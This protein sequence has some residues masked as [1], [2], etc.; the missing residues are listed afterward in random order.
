[1]AA[2]TE[3]KSGKKTTAARY[4]A[5]VRALLNQQQRTYTAQAGIRLR[6]SPTP[7]YQTLVLAILLSARIKADIAVAAARALFDAEMRDPRSMADASRQR[8][9]DALGKGGYRRYDE[10]TSTLLGRGAELVPRQA[11]F[12]RQGAASGACSRR[13]G[14]KSSYWTYLGFRPVRRECVPGVATGRTLPVAALVLERYGGDLRRLR[15]EPDPKKALLDIPGIGPTGADIFLRDVQGVW[16]EFAP[17]IDRKALEGA[18]RLGL[19]A[20]PKELGGLV[21]GRE[22]PRLADGLVHAALDKP[23]VDEV[24]AAAKAA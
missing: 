17:Y 22:M 20:S 23:L 10:R 9:V 21:Q 5:V 3:R 13:A 14:R 16:P 12:A 6:N 19:P 18:R 8:R 11:T 7:L 15:D 1:M 4:E 24:L 2:K